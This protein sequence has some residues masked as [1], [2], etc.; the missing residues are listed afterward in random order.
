MRVNLLP[1]ATFREACGEEYNIPHHQHN[2]NIVC[3][4]TAY[5]KYPRV[6]R[7]TFWVPYRVQTTPENMIVLK[8]YGYEIFFRCKVLSFKWCERHIFLRIQF[9][10]ICLILQFNSLMTY[11]PAPCFV[12][13]TYIIPTKAD[14]VVL[15]EK[16]ECGSVA[17]RALG[18]VNEQSDG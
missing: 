8:C 16:L 11:N 10:Y 1:S 12:H 18:V 5:P 17:V 6:L 4:D 3:L 13:V 15:L 7:H 9:A 2:N 14:G